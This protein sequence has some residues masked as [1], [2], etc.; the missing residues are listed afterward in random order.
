MI[1]GVKY[2][3]FLISL[4]EVNR[5]GSSFKTTFKMWVKDLSNEEEV[6]DHFKRFQEKR[7]REA[8][9]PGYTEYNDWCYQFKIGD[10]EFLEFI[11]GFVAL[12]EEKYIVL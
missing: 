1:K 2:S 11:M 6:R 12:P 5:K 10:K 4:S 3:S 8:K 7:E 9:K